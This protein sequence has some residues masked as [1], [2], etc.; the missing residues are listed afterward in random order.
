[1]ECCKKLSA[2]SAYSPVQNKLTEIQRGKTH[3]KEA[4]RKS[5]KDA[6]DT[7]LCLS[8]FFAAAALSYRKF[9][10]LYLPCTQAE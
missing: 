6:R 10:P 8:L 5:N 2:K 4:P 3:C 7:K 9:N 1:M